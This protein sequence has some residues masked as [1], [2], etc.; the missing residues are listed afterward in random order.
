MDLI[1]QMAW[2]FFV[3]AFLGWCTEVVYAA[4]NHGKFVNR[5]FLNG[6]VCPIYG[7]GVVTVLFILE[8]IHDKFA[9]LYLGSFLLT[10]VLEFVTGAVLDKLFHKHWWDYSN[11]RFNI[12][13]YVCLKFSI[14]WGF[15]C[16]IVVDMVHPFVRDIVSLVPQKLG[17]VILLVL[18]FAIIADMIMTVVGINKVSKHLKLM[19]ATAKELRELSD[20]LGSG[21]SDKAIHM[22]EKHESNK[23]E[24]S[25][26]REQIRE[27]IAELQKRYDD[28]RTGTPM[29]ARRLHSAFP[30]LNMI[31]KLDEIRNKSLR[32]DRE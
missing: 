7:F 23:A 20:S 10:S 5:G 9:L 14:I 3:Y 4:L 8:P 1:C 13:G 12:K 25:Q 26:K 27:K 22:A 17:A 2:Y 21:I 16:L 32:D 30:K 28:L 11:E 15:A 19:S 31:E 24:R 18:T 6:P 29:T